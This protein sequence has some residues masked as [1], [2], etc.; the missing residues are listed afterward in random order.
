MGVACRIPRDGTLDHIVQVTNWKP[1][2][3]EVDLHA[4][5]QSASIRFAYG[6]KIDSSWD[7]ANKPINV[8]PIGPRWRPLPV[9]TQA[10]A[11]AN[12]VSNQVNQL[13][14]IDAKF[15]TSYWKNKKVVPQM[16]IQVDIQ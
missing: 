5:C 2:K 13:I 8:P 11:S 12:S 4:E 6:G 15:I 16:A 1:S 14:A 9:R 3:I 10:K 7:T